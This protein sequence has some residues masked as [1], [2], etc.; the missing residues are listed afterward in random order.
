MQKKSTA[1]LA[2]AV[3]GLGTLAAVITGHVR[4]TQADDAFANQ[5]RVAIAAW[6]CFGEDGHV[7]VTKQPPAGAILPADSWQS[8]TNR[9]FCGPIDAQGNDLE[10]FCAPHHIA[11]YLDVWTTPGERAYMGYDPGHAACYPNPAA[12]S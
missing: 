5:H 1:Y 3:L 7:S 4:D 2:C 10:L 6:T 11:Y 12:K 8:P 9:P